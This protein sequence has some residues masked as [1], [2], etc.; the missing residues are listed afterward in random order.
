MANPKVAALQSWL[1]LK[2]LK[3]QLAVDGVGGPATRAGL[4]ALFANRAAPAIT[5]A[6]LV[7]IAHR[8]GCTVRQ[9]LAVAEV[10][11]SGGGF[12]AAGRPKILWERHYFWKRLQLRIPL[13][14]DP[15]PG[16]YT[17]DANRN[18]V[19]D[20]WEKLADAACRAPAAAFESASWGKFQIMGAW[21][22][23]LGYSSAAEFAWTMRESEA[24][25]FEALARYVEQFGLIGAI[26]AIDGNPANCVAFARGY[27]GKGFAKFNYDSRIAAAWRKLA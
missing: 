3:P 2:G 25:H 12:D 22:D 18:G 6:E 27:N 24:A 19:N 4:L 21:W 10:E 23:K 7:T 8:L 5:Q 9:L 20:S 26:R 11:S 13:I 15:V 17:L 1:N 14:S 16:G